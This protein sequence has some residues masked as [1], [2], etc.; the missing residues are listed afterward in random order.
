MYELSRTKNAYSSQHKIRLQLIL[1]SRIQE[2]I[3]N[4]ADARETSIQ[5]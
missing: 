4:E 3:I 2:F 5:S 1:K